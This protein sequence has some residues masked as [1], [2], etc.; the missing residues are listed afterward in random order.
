MK[1]NLKPIRDPLVV[2]RTLNPHNFRNKHQRI[3]STIYLKSSR[4]YELNDGNM[5]K[6]SPFEY[7]LIE[8]YV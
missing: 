7:V 4:R 8:V 2:F 1:K 5:G 6:C 3:I